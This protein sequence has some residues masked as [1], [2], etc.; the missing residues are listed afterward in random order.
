[1]VW[2]IIMEYKVINII[3][4]CGREF[5]KEFNNN[6]ERKRFVIIIRMEK[7]MNDIKKSVWR[8]NTICCP[9]FLPTFSSHF[10]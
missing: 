4:K 8:S 1:M 3:L 2:C 6:V 7:G 9:K 10:I 5:K